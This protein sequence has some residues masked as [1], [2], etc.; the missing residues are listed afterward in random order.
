MIWVQQ[1][2]FTSS[3]PIFMLSTTHIHA[4]LSGAVSVHSSSPANTFQ[5][6]L[7]LQSMQSLCLKTPLSVQLEC[8]LYK[9]HPSTSLEWFLFAV[10]LSS[11]CHRFFFWFSLSRC[12]QFW[13]SKQNMK[14]TGNEMT[15]LFS[16]EMQSSSW[17]WV[18]V[19]YFIAICSCFTSV[20][21][22][23]YQ[24]LKWFKRMRRYS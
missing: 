4:C 14:N 18:P 24:V 8:S 2:A 23:K 12:C 3:L 20:C 7:S 10:H 5:L 1:K 9:R 21:R 16:T 13:P 19:F 11:V 17:W 22:Y 15:W 6:S